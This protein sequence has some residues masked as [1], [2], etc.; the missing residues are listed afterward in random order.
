MRHTEPGERTPND[1]LVFVLPAFISG[2]GYSCARDW[3]ETSIRYVCGC[4]RCLDKNG[5]C[6]CY[7]PEDYR[8]DRDCEEQWR[9]RVVSVKTAICAVHLIV[10]GYTACKL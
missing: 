6:L 1:T 2:M 5:L 7:S 3:C 9:K 4:P 10:P 8:E